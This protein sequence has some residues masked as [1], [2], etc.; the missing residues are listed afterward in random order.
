M[1]LLIQSR[2]LLWLA[3][4]AVVP[5]AIL[6]VVAIGPD[7]LAWQLLRFLAGTF[8]FPYY[9]LQSL[10]GI[11]PG[12][13]EDL[14]LVTVALSALL[15]A[16]PFVAAHLLLLRQLRVAAASNGTPAA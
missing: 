16:L 10:L 5:A 3:L 7:S 15:A 6:D 9:A 14:S 13:E 4:L 12:I 2:A 1:R 11:D 8:G